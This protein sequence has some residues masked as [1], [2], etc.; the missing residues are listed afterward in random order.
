MDW[1]LVP[2]LWSSTVVMERIVKFLGM[3]VKLRELRAF[4][5]VS[6]G[7]LKIYSICVEGRDYLNVIISKTSTIHLILFFQYWRLNIWSYLFMMD[8]N[9]KIDIL[10]IHI[11]FYLRDC[12]QWQTSWCGRKGLHQVD[13]IVNQM[14][15][16]ASPWL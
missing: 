7:S 1:F 4:A 13:W 3:A 9:F 5:K 14:V 8:W 16:S 12:I 15:W 2:H 11:H 6:S 10:V